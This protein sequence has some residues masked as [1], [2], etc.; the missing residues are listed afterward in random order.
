MKTSLVTK[1]GLSLF[2]LGLC[3][4]PT[5][6][7]AQATAPEKPAHA[8][9]THPKT[10]HTKTTHTKKTH[11]TKASHSAKAAPLSS[12]EQLNAQSLAASQTK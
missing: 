9:T 4:A 12:T 5:L 10:T 1:I 8:K 11:S 6:A 2:A 3:A 7:Q